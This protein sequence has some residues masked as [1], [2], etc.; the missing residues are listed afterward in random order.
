MK[1]IKKTADKFVI[2]DADGYIIGSTDRDFVDVPK[3]NLVEIKQLIGE[4][5]VWDIADK[6]WNKTS[7]EYKSI[8]EYADY[9]NGFV[10]GYNQAIEDNKDRKYTEA[11]LRGAYQYAKLGAWNEALLGKD[12]S[13]FLN[14]D[15]YVDFVNSTKTKTEWNVEMVDGKLKL[16]N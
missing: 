16:A 12:A 3:L 15:A 9:T 2:E 5:D 8:S 14:I 6:S 1:L 11:E 7:S 10:E 4:A 13:D